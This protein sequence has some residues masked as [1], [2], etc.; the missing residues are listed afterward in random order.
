MPERRSEIRLPLPEGSVSG[1]PGSGKIL[2]ISPA[3]VRVEVNTRCVFARGELHRLVL[4][5]LLESV[6]IESRV[7]WTQSSWRNSVG[8]EDRQYVQTAGFAFNRLLSDPPSGT[9]SRLL[10][11]QAP[12]PS[13]QEPPPIPQVPDVPVAPRPERKRSEAPATHRIERIRAKPAVRPPSPLKLIEP[14]DGATTGQA[15]IEVVC[16]IDKPESLSG[17]RINGIEAIIEKDRGIAQIELQKGDNRIVS[18]VHRRDGTY[19][20]YLLGKILRSKTH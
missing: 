8:T 18:T 11:V 5:D 17:F 6:E 3:G 10:G 4:S 12:V 20:S 7:R 13:R 1:F 14:L 2:D 15:K 19:S 9:W 16:A